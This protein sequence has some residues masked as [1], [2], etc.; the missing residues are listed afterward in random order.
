MIKTINELKEFI[1]WAKE[2]KV[3]SVK[4]GDVAFEISNLAL[5]EA[6]ELKPYAEQPTSVGLNEQDAQ[7]QKEDDDLLMW[8]SRS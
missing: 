1:L 5:I 4:I 2:Q 8:S 6:T 3:S 7:E